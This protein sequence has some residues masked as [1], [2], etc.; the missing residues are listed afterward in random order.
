M[1][2]TAATLVGVDTV[3]LISVGTPGWALEPRRHAI[4]AARRAGV[5]HL[6]Y[7]SALHAPTTILGL[8]IGHKAT[9]DLST[10][11]GIPATLVRNGRYTEN[12]LRD[13]ATAREH[14]VIANGRL[15][16]APRKDFAE[17]AA[18]VLTTPGHE[19]KAYE[20]SGDTAWSYE[21]FAAV[22]Q[23]VLG[24]PVRYQELTPEQEHAQLFGFGLDE[25][26]VGFLV[27]LNADMHAGADPRRP[28]P[29]HR[30]PDRAARDDPAQLGL[31]HTGPGSG[32][33]VCAASARSR[34]RYQDPTSGRG[35]SSLRVRNGCPSRTCGMV[36]GV[37]IDHPARTN[38]GVEP[39]S[40]GGN[41]PTRGPGG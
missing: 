12:H 19:G 18:V 41:G 21:E 34:L 20:L 5:G 24:A 28:R 14:G 38:G 35:T 2:A 33:P 10:A 39:A 25:G 32:R 40:V 27:A 17:A 37:T 16:T 29:P 8:A 1:D 11:S 13:F 26:T 9:E 3:L 22:A 31:T 23:R 4:E 36:V 6:V 7:T 15:A 30:P